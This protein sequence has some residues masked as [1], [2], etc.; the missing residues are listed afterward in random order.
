MK[1]FVT[2]FVLCLAVSS[3]SAVS[4]GFRGG[5]F[6]PPHNE[7]VFGVGWFP[8]CSPETYNSPNGQPWDSLSTLP[9][10]PVEMTFTIDNSELPTLDN[11]IPFKT[12]TF[13]GTNPT[14]LSTFSLTF[15]GAFEETA[16]SG[17]LQFE[18]PNPSLLFTEQDAL[19]GFPFASFVLGSF[20]GLAFQSKIFGGPGQ[21]FQVVVN[22][23]TW[24]IVDLIATPPQTVATGYF[25]T[26]CQAASPYNSDTSAC[27]PCD[28]NC[29]D[30]CVQP[31]TIVLCSE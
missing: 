29:D 5:V 9:A 21:A 28:R 26:C 30:T 27:T 17:P 13:N 22:G 10:F 25:E 12:L 11:M 3:V 19:D 7:T 6:Y 4:L 14:P 16:P 1:T 20:N 8:T 31:S 15:S 18:A 23:F 2:L 24:E